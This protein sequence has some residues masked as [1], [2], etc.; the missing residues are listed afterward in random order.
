[1][2]VTVCSTSA[3]EDAYLADDPAD[4]SRRL[5]RQVLGAVSDYERAMGRLRLAAGRRHK[6]DAGGS[7]F[8]A[9]PFGYRSERGELVPRTGEAE[10]LALITAMHAEQWPP[11]RPA[12]VRSSPR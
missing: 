2:G 7:A 9:P 8:G 1:M 4:P 11:D 3:A 6:T 12:C 10:A 5:I